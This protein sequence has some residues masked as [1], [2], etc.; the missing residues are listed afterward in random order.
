[1]TKRKE[2]NYPRF[3][4]NEIMQLSCNSCVKSVSYNRLSFT[5]EF[6]QKLY[7]AWVEEPSYDTIYKVMASH[8][9]PYDVIGYV[10]I[11][12]IINNFKRNGQ[13]SGAKNT[14]D[15]YQAN[16][17]RTKNSENRL[18]ASGFF[19]KTANGVRCTDKLIKTLSAMDKQNSVEENIRIL[20][21]RCEDIG[22]HMIYRLKGKIENNVRQNNLP[23]YND[24][25]VR[26]YKD[27]GFIK[28]CT[29]FMFSLTDD[30]I[31]LLS[32]FTHL[33]LGDRLKVLGID[34]HDLPEATC[35]RIARKAR[36]YDQSDNFV[37]KIIMNMNDVPF[38]K[39]LEKAYE[40]EAELH[41]D[42]IR[43]ALPHLSFNEK[44]ILCTYIHGL[45]K[46]YVFSTDRILKHIGLSR[47]HY[48]HI[49]SD[50]SYGM[51]EEK[52]RKDFETVMQV[53]TYKG[54]DKGVRTIHMMMKSVTGVQFSV[55]K[56]RR[57]LR[58][59]GVITDIRKTNSFHQGV[60]RHID[61]MTQTNYL[62]RMFRLGRPGTL[63]LTDVTYLKCGDHE[64]RYFSA[65]K[66]AV[67]GRIYG[68]EVSDRN[69]IKL[70]TDT[71]EAIRQF[72]FA[73]GS[74]Y[75]TDQGSTYLSKTFQD[76]A[77]EIGFIHSMSRRGNCWDNAPMESFWGHFK[78]ECAYKECHS[79]ADLRALISDYID[80]Y[81]NDRPQWT[82]R[83]MTPI[84]YEAY[85]NNLSNDEY[86]RYVAEEYGRYEL[87]I[88]EAGM[89]AKKRAIDI[90][91]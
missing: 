91:A 83:K 66:D 35:Y 88:R 21:I 30:A 77:K 57:L 68:F 55:G 78:D 59:N 71:L 29:N 37:S 40:R 27:N 12:S 6:R 87:M 15:S 31:A 48:Y 24:S 13:P 44:K 65:V 86:N 45:K 34:I 42:C 62:K 9:I 47:S 14:K 90:G 11:H 1:M 79:V 72:E 20:G 3:T 69:D 32:C 26:K 16:H 82:R 23:K 36:L 51:K 60:Q 80:Y 5:F 58:K 89:K 38:L 53:V 33:S 19:K 84:N 4:D 46:D 43:N 61:E 56:I 18:I 22:Y 28:S 76:K 8:D 7:D 85:L 25:V 52:E 75:H 2:F 49:L 67:S 50:D 54:Y 63:L 70:A 17:K 64:T 41:F 10:R 39:N 74:I 73:P 81:N